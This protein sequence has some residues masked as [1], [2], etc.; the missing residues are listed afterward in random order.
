[1]SL[2][3]IL[4]ELLMLDQQRLN[5]LVLARQR[6][7]QPNILKLNRLQIGQMGLL[8]G[9]NLRKIVRLELI[10]HIIRIPLPLSLILGQLPPEPILLLPQPHNL[11]LILIKGPTDPGLGLLQL[12]VL[13][14]QQVLE[15]PNLQ[16]VQL[17]IAQVLSL[18][19]LQFGVE[20]AA[21][22]ADLG[23]FQVLHLGELEAQALVLAQQLLD[24]EVLAAGDGAL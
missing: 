6:I 20:L 5:L 13:P 17:G 12:I 10:P 1:M 21:C 11:K 24:L 22:L 19:A 23:G 4:L 16:L 7:L 2:I 9:L 18:E 15:L 8:H 3:G 14:L